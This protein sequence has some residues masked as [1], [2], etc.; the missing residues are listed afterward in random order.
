M[1]NFML[2]GNELD[3]LL[4]DLK[5]VN[6][7]LGGRALTLNALKKLLT[8]CN[9]KTEITI[10]DIGCGDGEMLRLCAEYGQQKGFIF[11]LI[12]VDA[13]QN[14]ITIAQEKSSAYKNIEYYCCEVS[15][16]QFENLE[17]DIA[18]CTLFLHHIPESQIPLLLKKICSQSKVGVIINDLH[19]SWF[20]FQLFKVFS[21]FFIRTKI[22]KHDGLV[23]VARAF[24]RKD[25]EDQQDRIKGVT[26]TMQWKWAF[27]WQ[28]ILQKTN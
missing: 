14:I 6:S 17:F 18:L 7:Y 13:N 12:G 8:Q 2:S 3:L 22:A 24:K 28:W 19:R 1:D 4:N 11:K 21:F 16:K 25:L 27:R 26:S 9:R 15:S 20:A 5:T 10:M 23:S